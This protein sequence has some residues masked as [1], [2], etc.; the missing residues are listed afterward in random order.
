VGFVRIATPLKGVDTL[1]QHVRHFK[2]GFSRQRHNW[3]K[4]GIITDEEKYNYLV[5][6][7]AKSLII[8]VEKL[9]KTSFFPAYRLSY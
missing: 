6:L 1:V 8:E 4:L 2:A 7:R 3:L 9:L 5:E